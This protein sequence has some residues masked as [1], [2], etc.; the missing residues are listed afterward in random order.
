M[1]NCGHGRM[2]SKKLKCEQEVK[3]KYERRIRIQRVWINRKTLLFQFSGPLS[4]LEKIT[5]FFKKVNF[6]H[7]RN[8]QYQ[9]TIYHERVLKFYIFTT[10]VDI[11]LYEIGTKLSGARGH[12]YPPTPILGNTSSC[13]WY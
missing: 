13:C 11:K 3:S 10:F 7:I 1:Q 12:P 6:K 8:F 5:I 2:G 9:R 4:T